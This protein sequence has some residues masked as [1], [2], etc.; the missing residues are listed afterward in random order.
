MHK[1]LAIALGAGD[2]RID[3]AE[4]VATACDQRRRDLVAHALVHGGIAYHAAASIDLCLAGLELRL[5][6]QHELGLRDD[7][8]PISDGK[9]RMIEMNDRSATT[10]ST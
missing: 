4:H 7:T 3:P 9:A 1:E 6:E 5:D 8:P 10:R 2:R